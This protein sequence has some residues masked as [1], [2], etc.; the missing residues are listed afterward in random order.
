M[1][2]PASAVADGY[3]RQR[4]VDAVS[5]TF[6]VEVTDVSDEVMGES[7]A[8]IRF[9]EPGVTRFWLD[10]ASRS[11]GRRTGMSVDRVA[12]DGVPLSF[13]HVSDR[14]LIRLAAPP[15]VGDRRAIV[16]RYRGI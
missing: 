3:P 15:G 11:P 14:L 16:V 7:T 8:T 6:R 12:C 1:S 9:T 10:L 13:E 2:T 4:G 5:Y